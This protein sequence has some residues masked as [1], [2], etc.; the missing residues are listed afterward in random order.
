VGAYYN[1]G[2]VAHKVTFGI[3]IFVWL[4]AYYRYEYFKP[5]FSHISPRFCA[6]S[7]WTFSTCNRPYV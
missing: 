2:N 3:E 5:I 1:T 7:D 6:L 4:L